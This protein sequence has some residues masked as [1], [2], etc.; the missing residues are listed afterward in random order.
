MVS[1]QTKI[2]QPSL[3][4]AFASKNTSISFKHSLFIK[5]NNDNHLFWKQVMAT[6]KGHKLTHFL[7]S[8]AKR[9]KFLSLEDAVIN[10]EYS[11]WEQQD[12]L[13]V[14]RLLSSMTEGILTRMVGCESAFQ[15][16]TKLNQYF[17]AQTRAKVSQFKTY[18]KMTKKDR[19]Q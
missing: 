6:V 7:D 3:T 9:S 12:H 17:A 8:T 15:I 14:S 13:L 19:Y 16:W 4:I 2:S 10:P 5:I 1:E 18:S 11:D